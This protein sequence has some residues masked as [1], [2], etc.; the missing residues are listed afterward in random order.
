MGDIV[1]F[2][3]KEIFITKKFTP[4]T[5]AQS[6]EWDILDKAFILTMRNGLLEWESNISEVE[7]IKWC[8]K[9]I[10]VITTKNSEGYCGDFEA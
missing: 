3:H 4:E 5:L 6:V 10:E 9:V 7:A 2:P 1:N 8:L